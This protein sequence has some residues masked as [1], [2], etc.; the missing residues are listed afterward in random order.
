MTS[1]A[2]AQN[3]QLLAADAIVLGSGVHMAGMESSM[4]GFLE[5]TAPLWMQGQLTGKLGAV[6]ASGGAGGRG[7]GELTLISLLATLAEL[8]HFATAGCHWGPLAET[9]PGTGAPGPTETQLASARAH[10]RWVAECA[11]RWT[12]LNE[13]K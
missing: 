7:G 5:R 4:R 13:L 8:D 2:E 3:E 10:G 1:A 11:A 12:P 6:F 9:N